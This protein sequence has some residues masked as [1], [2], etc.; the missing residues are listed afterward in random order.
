MMDQPSFEREINAYLVNVDGVLKSKGLF[1]DKGSAKLNKIQQ[2]VDMTLNKMRAMQRESR[3][4]R[5]S[6]GQLSS[7]SISKV[8]VMA[9]QVKDGE[10]VPLG[11][12]F[13]SLASDSI[14]TVPEWKDAFSKVSVEVSNFTN[15]YGVLISNMDS[16]SR[17]KIDQALASIIDKAQA[18][19][20]SDPSNS[21][22]TRYLRE[23]LLALRALESAA[24]SQQKVSA[25]GMLEM[26]VKE[27]DQERI[28]AV[29]NTQLIQR[30]LSSEQVTVIN[31]ANRRIMEKLNDILSSQTSYDAAIR[32]KK[33]KLVDSDLEIIRRVI[34]NQTF[35][36]NLGRSL[37]PPRNG[38]TKLGRLNK[39]TTKQHFRYAPASNL[40]GGLGI[41]FKTF[42]AD[43]KPTPFDILSAVKHN[44]AMIKSQGEITVEQKPTFIR[45]VNSLTP[46]SFGG[47]IIAYNEAKR[48]YMM[49]V[50]HD[51]GGIFMYDQAQESLPNWARVF[52]TGIL[53]LGIPATALYFVGRKT[54]KKN[55]SDE[56]IAS[57]TGEV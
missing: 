33:L 23:S 4:D 41:S 26:A 27:K 6:A 32:N 14:F 11:A 10:K 50:K 24:E 52:G 16:L 5:M 36:T 43:E 9:E 40:G 15:K 28:R 31:D 20:E 12:V 44:A 8:S 35:A 1:H 55:P 25:A 34:Q 3:L 54:A 38:G 56:I 51:L 29:A 47:D 13:G 7:Q 57:I 37:P 2:E 39:N 18:G 48:H 17:T 42:E 45:Q 53:Y 49:L 30:Q 46:E 19:F 21:G 22:A